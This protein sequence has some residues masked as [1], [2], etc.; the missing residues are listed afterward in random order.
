MANQ[1][2]DKDEVHGEQVDTI[3]WEGENVLMR[4]G[5]PRAWLDGGLSLE[6]KGGEK[7]EL[8]GVP[9]DRQGERAD[10]LELSQD[11]K[12]CVEW[13]CLE[14]KRD[15]QQESVHQDLPA[16][17]VKNLPAHVVKHLPAQLVKS[18]KHDGI[19]EDHGVQ[20]VQE[21]EKGREYVLRCSYIWGDHP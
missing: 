13:L 11:D 6:N 1:G 2:N 12:E 5:G 9:D 8:H 20:G 10:R 4:V 15:G 16:C 14:S 3:R 18:D 7:C 21:V 17:L 19:Q